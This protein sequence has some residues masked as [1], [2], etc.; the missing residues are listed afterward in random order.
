[1]LGESKVNFVRDRD[2]IRV[3]NRGKFTDIRFLV[4]DREIR[5]NDL[6]I[7]FDN[8]D[9]LEPQ[10]DETIPP[11]QQ[12]RIIQ[13]AREGRYIDRIEFKYR[14]TGNVLK[15]RAKLLVFGKRFVDPYS[16]EQ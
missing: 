3:Y 13:I 16:I 6:K 10:I 9:K 14:T 1:M 11:G 8:G 12:S 4:E 15:G 2:E 5:L 7:V